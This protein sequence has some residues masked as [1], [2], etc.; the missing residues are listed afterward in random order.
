MNRLSN[1]TSA[2]THEHPSALRAPFPHYSTFPKQL[3]VKEKCV[4]GTQLTCP[5]E[6]SQAQ[7]FLPPGNK[8]RGTRLGRSSQKVPC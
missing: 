1:P 8:L 4:W 6:F 5:A 3:W 2:G 7:G